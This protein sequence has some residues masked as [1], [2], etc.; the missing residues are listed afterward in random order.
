M[1]VKHQELQHELVVMLLF[2][3][4]DR[5]KVAPFTAVRLGGPEAFD[6]GSAEMPAP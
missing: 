5:K 6:D 3:T 1:Q 2:L 4:R